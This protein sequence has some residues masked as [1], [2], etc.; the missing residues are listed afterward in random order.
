[1]VAWR[2]GSAHTLGSRLKVVRRLVCLWT[3]LLALAAAWCVRP[4]SRATCTGPTSLP[5]NAN[6]NGGLEPLIFCPHLASSEFEWS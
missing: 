3:T 2:Y 5:T 6:D 4:L 1:L